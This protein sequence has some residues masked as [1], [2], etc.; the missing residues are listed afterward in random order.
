MQGKDTII[1]EFAVS[2]L[3]TLKLI[4]KKTYIFID[5]ELF[6]QCKHLLLINPHLNPDQKKINSIDEAEQRLSSDLEKNFSI[7]Q[8]GITPEQEFWGHCSNLQAWVENNYDSRFLHRNLAFPLLEDLSKFS[9]YFKVKF[10]EE[11]LK[12]ISENPSFYTQIIEYSGYISD[13]EL[14]FSVLVLD[15]AEAIKQINDIYHLEL[16]W[17]DDR[18]VEHSYSIKNK[19]VIFLNLSD[20][21]LKEVPEMIKK[22]QFLEG[23]NLKNNSITEIPNWIEEMSNLKEIIL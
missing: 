12:R 19:H 7:E 22:L 10:K 21:K 18:R 6:R 2:E 3:I 11:M 17:F 9:E 20:S 13:E 4:G 5:G 23:L 15:E 1:K 16:L 8:L 14:L